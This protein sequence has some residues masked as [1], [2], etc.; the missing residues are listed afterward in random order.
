M[1]TPRE[2]TGVP[3]TEKQFA[4][5]VEDLLRYMGWTFYH[6]YEQQVYA[7]RSTKDFPDFLCV[8]E[9]QMV[10]LEL[11]SEKGKVTLGQAW[12]L[13]ALVKACPQAVVRVMRPSQ[14]LELVELL[15]W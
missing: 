15:K 2:V 10:V 13:A 8:R 4:T 3:Q 6:V 1:K 12:W 5:A 7:R 14:W 11:K 9:K